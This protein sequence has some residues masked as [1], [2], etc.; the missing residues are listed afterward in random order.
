VGGQRAAASGAGTPPTVAVVGA[1][2]AIG[3]AVAQRL[4]A[5]LAPGARVLCLGPTRTDVGDADWS[6]LDLGDPVLAT[7]LAGID[8]VV[9]AWLDPTIGAA[10]GDAL[11]ATTAS[12]IDA[13]DGAGVGRLVLVSSTM[14][15]GVDGAR[16]APAP[17]AA[18]AVDAGAAGAAGDWAHAEH[19]SSAWA[20]AAG[21]RLTIVRPAV[22]VG[23]SIDTAF[24]RYFESPRLLLLGECEPVWQFTHLDDLVDAVGRIIDGD[25]P[26]GVVA[27]ACGEG[28]GS[29]AVEARLGVKPLRLPEAVA[30]AAA[31]RLHRAGVSPSPAADL[32]FLTGPWTV[33]ATALDDA[34]WHPRWTNEQVLDLLARRRGDAVTLAGRRVGRGEAASLGA[35]GAAAAVLAAVA[36]ARARRR[37][38]PW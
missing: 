38:A 11:R 13:L 15:I 3:S 14:A 17:E 27:V 9:G 30:V 4:I 31:Q 35:A 23:E 34:G 19:A 1:H 32:A 2:T 16:P 10:T 36:L 29:E 21:R 22:L 24:T 26:D 20:G 8:V 18:A 33:H 28:V 7:A 5:D 6:V 12:V 25:G 37:S